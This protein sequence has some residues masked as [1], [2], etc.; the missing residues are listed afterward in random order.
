MQ[1]GLKRFFNDR[2]RDEQYPVPG[3]MSH[4]ILLGLYKTYGATLRRRSLHAS[5]RKT[6]KT[7]PHTQCDGCR[8]LYGY[9]GTHPLRRSRYGWL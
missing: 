7:A 5:S 2:K 8:L 6:T 1:G 9:M 4:L 3:F